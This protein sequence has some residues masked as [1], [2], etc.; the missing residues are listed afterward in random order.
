[1]Q[2]CVRGISMFIFAFAICCIQ[3][4]ENLDLGNGCGS[5]TSGDISQY[6]WS[7]SVVIV[8]VVICVLLV[9][10]SVIVTILFVRSGGRGKMEN[11]AKYEKVPTEDNTNT[12]ET[13]PR[14]YANM[15]ESAI[16]MDRAKKIME[17]EYDNEQAKT[18][19]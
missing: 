15:T 3:G 18:R 4:E 19:K 6:E 9:I 8:V 13:E 17:I 16:D 1:M 7:L 5:T 10:Y 11:I 14:L 2:S 12:W